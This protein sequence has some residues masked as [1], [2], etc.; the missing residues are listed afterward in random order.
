MGG[1]TAASEAE[2]EDSDGEEVEPPRMYE[3]LLQNGTYREGIS[4][5]LPVGSRRGGW[6]NVM[7]VSSSIFSLPEASNAVPL[8]PTAGHQGETEIPLG[9]TPPPLSQRSMITSV[10]IAMPAPNAFEPT[11]RGGSDGISGETT[12]PADR[13]LA[14][15]FFGVHEALGDESATPSPQSLSS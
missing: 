11:R 2:K 10:L 1:P 12:L 9:N 14:D 3:I 4:A 5:G 6:G 8:V 15:M 7:P 13:R